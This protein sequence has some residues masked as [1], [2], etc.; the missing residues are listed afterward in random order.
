MEN[1]KITF[2][3]GNLIV[4]STGLNGKDYFVPDSSR[5]LIYK[6]IDIIENT[7]IVPEDKRKPA[8]DSYLIRMK[9]S[10]VFLDSNDKCIW[11]YIDSFSED[12]HEL[13]IDINDG[14]N[15][16]YYSIISSELTDILK[17]ISGFREIDFKNLSKFNNTAITNKNNNKSYTMTDE[18]L[19][20]FNSIMKNLDERAQLCAGP[21]D[22]KIETNMDNLNLSMDW[23]NDDCNILAVE[24][25]IFKLNEEDGKKL[26]S[27]IDIVNDN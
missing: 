13:M 11:I 23:A 10:M 2:S 4:Y 6:L 19:I 17:E 1:N 14:E 24:G 22:V 26:M 21:Y 5:D 3:K 27:I 25:N 9:N 12:R 7:E 15:S 8:E 18:E 16:F 20:W